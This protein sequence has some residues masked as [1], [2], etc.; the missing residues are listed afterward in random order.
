MPQ[1]WDRTSP[2]WWHRSPYHR[3][4]CIFG[5][6]VLMVCGYFAGWLLVLLALVVTQ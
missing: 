1:M 5:A 4:F 6:L 2:M 3:M